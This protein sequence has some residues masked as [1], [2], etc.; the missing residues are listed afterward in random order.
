[1]R[2]KHKTEEA[3]N[4]NSP[5]SRKFRYNMTKLIFIY[6]YQFFKIY[7]LNDFQ[8]LFKNNLSLNLLKT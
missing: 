3:I 8:I 7:K 1:M 2:Y 5:T 4:Q 6:L